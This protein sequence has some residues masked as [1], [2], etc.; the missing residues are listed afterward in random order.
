M[1]LF[2]NN[3]M[4]SQVLTMKDTIEVLE[5]AYADLVAKEAVCRPRIDIQIP[6][7]DPHKAYQW[8]SMEGGSVGGYFAIRM[9]SDIIYE[10]EYN[11]A[12]TQEKYCTQP[13]L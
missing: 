11:G 7:S 4:V 3:D 13:G 2:I 8:G 6:T 1:T 10:T 12:L 9:K 5:K